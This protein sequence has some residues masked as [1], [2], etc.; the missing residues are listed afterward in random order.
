MKRETVVTIVGMIAGVVVWCVWLEWSSTDI[1]P[2][3]A[4]VG[5]LLSVSWMGWHLRS[6]AT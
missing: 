3:Q 6:M 2:M 5:L 4:F 1:S